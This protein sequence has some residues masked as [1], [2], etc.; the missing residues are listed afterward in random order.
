ML[1]ST[2]FDVISRAFTNCGHV[3]NA[4]GGRVTRS[5]LQLHFLRIATVV[6]EKFMR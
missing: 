6:S 3:A 1:Y 4:S 5:A 2:Q